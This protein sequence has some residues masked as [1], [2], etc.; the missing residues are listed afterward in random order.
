M[1]SFFIVALRISCQ[2]C[3]DFFRVHLSFCNFRTNQIFADKMAEMA[4]KMASCCPGGG[5][6][7][8]VVPHYCNHSN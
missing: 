8:G 6:P 3:V 4:D 1:A 2:S 7:D 5:L